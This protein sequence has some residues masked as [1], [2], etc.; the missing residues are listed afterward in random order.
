MRIVPVCLAW[1]L[2]S[3]AASHVERRADG[4][5]VLKCD[6]QRQC[7]ERAQRVCGDQGFSVLGGKR[8]KKIYG[9]PGQQV[10]VG[11]DEMYVQCAADRPKDTPN[12]VAGQ[13]HL[14][15]R[16]VQPAAKR[17]KPKASTLVCRP[18]ET[19]KCYGPAACLGGQACLTDG[20]GFGPCDCGPARPSGVEVDAGPTIDESSQ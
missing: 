6:E 4:S 12:G 16:R 1:F 3:C 19:Q 13:W 7:L 5:Y 10:V 11:D 18:G 8:D 17:P 2:I 9:V 15:Q 14:P 20:S